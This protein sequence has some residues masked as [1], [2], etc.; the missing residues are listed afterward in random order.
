MMVTVIVSLLPS[1]FFS[2]DIVFACFYCTWPRYVYCIDQFSIAHES[3]HH[4]LFL[5]VL[6]ILSHPD[7]RTVFLD[8]SAFFSCL[9]RDSP[10]THWRLNET[11]YDDLPSQMQDD[12]VISTIPATLSVLIELSIPARAEYNGTRVQ[13]VAES[14]DGDSV[15]SDTATLRIQGI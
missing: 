13:C 12:L 4:P 7:D 8:D 6:V 2:S 1:I 10:A 11:D 9:T 5:F 15:D 14:D 3:P